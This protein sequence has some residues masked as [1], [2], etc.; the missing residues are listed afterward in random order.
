MARWKDLCVDARDPHALAS[1]WGAAL[2]RQAVA[3]REGLCRVDGA[4]PEETVWFNPVPEPKSVKHRVH[5]DLKVGDLEGLR[6]LGA[7][8]LQAPGEDRSW[9]VLADPDGGELCAFVRDGLPSL[10]GRCFEMVVHAGDPAAQA[11]WWADVLG[12]EAVP[13]E[14]GPWS[15][16]T[17]IPGAPFEFLVFAPVPEPKTVKNR[18]H[19]DVESADVDGLVAR[20]ARVLREPDHNVRWHVLADPEGNEFCVFSPS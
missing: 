12:G 15:S 20:G 8:V 4:R 2:G 1:F 19:W 17:G 6:G 14:D 10:P 11:R 16:V 9:W 13:D 7:R 5:L 18:V 3:V